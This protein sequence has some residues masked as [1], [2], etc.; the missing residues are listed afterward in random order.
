VSDRRQRRCG[1]EYLAVDED[2][3]L[4]FRVKVAVKGVSDGGTRVGRRDVRST[5]HD[6][7]CARGAAEVELVGDV[8]GDFADSETS[9][10]GQAGVSVEGRRVSG[11]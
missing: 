5:I 11:V 8:D 3:D 1:R 7:G 2:L 10:G 4:P 6:R 9:V